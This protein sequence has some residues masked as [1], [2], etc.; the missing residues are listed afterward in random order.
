MLTGLHSAT[1]FWGG[2]VLAWAIIVPLLVKNAMVNTANATYLGMPA[3]KAIASSAIGATARYW[4][5]RPGIMIMTNLDTFHAYSLWNWR[6]IYEGVR[7]MIVQLTRRGS[8]KSDFGDPDAEV[9]PAGPSEQIPAWMWLGGL[10]ASIIMTVLVGL[11]FDIGVG[12]GIPSIILAF[13]FAFIG[14]QASGT[15]DLNPTG[16]IAKT[17]QFV[18]GGVT[19]AKGWTETPLL[20]KAQLQNLMSG[21]IASA[22]A[23]QSVEMV[24]DLK[25]GHLLRAS[26]RTQ[27][28]AQAIGT[29]FAC[30]I[31]LGLYIVYVDAYPCVNTVY[32]NKPDECKFENPGIPHSAG[33][34]ALVCGAITVLLIAARKTLPQKFGRWIP[35]MSAVGVA[36]VVQDTK[37]GNAMLIGALIAFFWHKKNPASWEVWGF[38]LASGFLAGDGLGGLLR[39]ILQI[40]NFKPESI[41][42]SVA[43]GPKTFGS[44]TVYCG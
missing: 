42:S 26:P 27:F 16:A 35:N 38:A 25:T 30:F 37:Y 15:T 24:G 19:R 11:M 10:V 28:I 8:Y 2:Q 7:G 36:W 44:A 29:F 21:A 23:S 14:I 34:A 41:G 1:S 39:A 4:L 17:A 32:V 6:S 13:I 33:I 43:C 3:R 20:E 22:V 18:Y 31:S 40:L 12:E 9:D 5:L